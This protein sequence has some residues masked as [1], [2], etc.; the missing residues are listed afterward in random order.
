M[1]D[2]RFE[3]EFTAVPPPE[4]APIQQEAEELLLLPGL[5]A[6][7]SRDTFRCGNYRHG[8]MQKPGSWLVWVP[9]SVQPGDPAW[10]VTEAARRNAYNGM[11]SGWC[12]DCAQRLSGLRAASPIDSIIGKPASKRLRSWWRRLLG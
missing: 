2:D 7:R 12:L 5:R 1:S 4:T 10:S 6:V 8:R 9:D 3:F 11:L